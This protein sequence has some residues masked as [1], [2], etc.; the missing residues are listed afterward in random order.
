ML[1]PQSNGKLGT[2]KL[3]VEDPLAFKGLP[4]WRSFLLD[5]TYGDGESE[6]LAGVV[7]FKAGGDGWQFTLKDPTAACMLRVTGRTHDEALLII[8]GLLASEKA[9]WEVD[10]FE[11]GRKKRSRGRRG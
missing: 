1:K 4:A 9:P 3:F 6:R 10:P 2:G 5:Q 7:I 8:E 11:V